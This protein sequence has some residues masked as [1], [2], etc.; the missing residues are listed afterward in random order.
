M[1]IIFEG[2][3]NS[4]KTTLAKHVVSSCPGLIEY[5]HAGGPPRDEQAE[6][7]CLLQQEE[8]L[9]NGGTQFAIDRV[10]A[11]SQQVYNP[12]YYRDP[13][14]N[15]RLFMISQYNEVF[16]VYCR[17]P[18][19]R[20]LRI[21]DLTWREDESEEHRQKIIHGLH[22]FVLRYDRVMQQVPCLVYDF[23]D[24]SSVALRLALVAAV[25]GEQGAMTWLRSMQN[26][27]R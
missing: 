6:N 19:D 5:W 26:F 21:Q 7:R 13:V 15:T 23:D 14:R 25:R 22:D 16:I 4:G 24:P 1:H 8:M 10:T 9:A 17:P 2:P 18:T 12:S 11:I 3:D 27:K 20:L